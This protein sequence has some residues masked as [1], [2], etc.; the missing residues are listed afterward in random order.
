MTIYSLFATKLQTLLCLSLFFGI[1]FTHSAHFNPSD[2]HTTRIKSEINF[3]KPSAQ[4]EFSDQI[5]TKYTPAPLGNNY[6]IPVVFH[7]ISQN[8]FAITDQQIINA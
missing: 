7:I 4:S 2:P 1:F 6:T 5:L 8:P 3:K